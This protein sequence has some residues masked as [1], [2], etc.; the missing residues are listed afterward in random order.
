MKG[1]VQPWQTAL[2]ICGAWISLLMLAL[3]L[4]I[5][6]SGYQ[7]RP[8]AVAANNETPSENDTGGPLASLAISPGRG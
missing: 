5:L 4:W 6:N 7:P 1:L 2:A 8:L 3:F